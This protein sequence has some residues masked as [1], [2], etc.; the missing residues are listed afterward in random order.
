[1]DDRRGDRV[2]M[3]ISDVFRLAGIAAGL[4]LM[5]LIFTAPSAA[6]PVAAGAPGEKADGVLYEDAT[7]NSAATIT[8]VLPNSATSQ[9][10]LDHVSRI[11]IKENVII[12]EWGGTATTLLPQQYVCAIAI[13][14]HNPR[15]AGTE[16]A[17]H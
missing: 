15:A 1:M 12:I 17:G 5:L 7:A 13:N 2:S 6:A 10:T 8:Q 11:R 4:L 14:K 9:L 16:P 3:G